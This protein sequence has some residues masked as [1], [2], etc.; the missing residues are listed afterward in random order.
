MFMLHK[1]SRLFFDEL[2]NCEIFKE[3]PAPWSKLCFELSWFIIIM[4][5]H[6]FVVVVINLL[7]RT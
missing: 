5:K 1:E 6:T 3:Y 4:Q 2:S 7:F